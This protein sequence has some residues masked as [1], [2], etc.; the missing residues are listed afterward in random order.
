MAPNRPWLALS[1]VCAL[2]AA[3]LAAATLIVD[4]DQDVDAADG[5]CSLREAIAAANTD[6]PYGDCPAGSGPDRIVLAIP[7]P[8]TILLTA[9]LPQIEETLRLQ[10]PGSALLTIDGQNLHQLVAFED[11]IGDGWLGVDGL[12]LARGVSNA[13]GYGGGALV[14]VGERALFRDVIFLE[15]TATN[16]GGGLAARDLSEVRIEDCWFSG[17]VAEGPTGG[18]GLMVDDAVGI[19][20]E[21]STFS[22]NAASHE[23]GGGG[24]LK[25]LRTAATIRASTVS[26]NWANASGGGLVIYAIPSAASL[27]LFDS[28]VTRN[29]AD[30]DAAGSGEEGGGISFAIDAS[31]SATFAIGN[32]IV[33]E[34]EASGTTPVPD[35]DLPVEVSLSNHGF[36]LIG[37]NAGAAFDFPA[38]APNAADDYV[39][40]TAAPID[41][42]LGALAPWGGTMPSHRPLFSP[43]SRALDS[44]SCAGAGG[45]QRGHGDAGAHVRAFD[46]DTVANGAGSDGCDIGAHER[47]A[48]PGAEP[49][50]FADGFEAGHTLLW[51]SEAP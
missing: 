25:V 33:A 12:T 41:P 3:P 51:S 44:G 11:E 21:R 13:D 14:E 16:G 48:D 15:N 5:F 45:D 2:S 27:A 37:D 29:R 30:E 32:T 10:G 22:D 49:A 7:T 39:G 34:N 28:T 42:R 47:G 24:G 50:L 6:A 19:V 38:G 23:N 31:S 40:T 17:N 9:S 26:G 18:G 8:A 36:N 4:S 35:L 43:D 46:L 20:I 1:F